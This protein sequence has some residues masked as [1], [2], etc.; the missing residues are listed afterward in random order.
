VTEFVFVLMK[1]VVVSTVTLQYQMDTLE[2][3]FN[4]CGLEKIVLRASVSSLKNRV[5]IRTITVKADQ[6]FA[7]GQLD[8]CA[9]GPLRWI[10]TATPEVAAP[11]LKES[12][13]YMNKKQTIPDLEATAYLSTN[14]TGGAET[15]FYLSQSEQHD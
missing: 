4:A 8:I 12:L 14:V 7:H 5:G 9:V 3:V 15:W 1:V 10:F 6:N 11:V 2:H 13:R